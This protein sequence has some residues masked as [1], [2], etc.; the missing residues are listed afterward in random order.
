MGTARNKLPDDQIDKPGPD[1]AVVLTARQC[2]AKQNHELFAGL[3]LFKAGRTKRKQTEL[4]SRECL[5]SDL[6]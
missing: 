2:L 1:L 5:I 4:K 6:P 3:N